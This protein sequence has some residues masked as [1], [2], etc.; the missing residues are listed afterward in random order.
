MDVR[1]D[2]SQAA[3]CDRAREVATAVIAPRVAEIDQSEEYPWDKVGALV[4][5]GFV[6]LTIL[7]AYGGAGRSYFD[8]AFVIEKM[9][10]V[11][12]VTG[13]IAVEIN[14]GAIGAIIAHGSEEQKKLAADMVL[15]GDKPAICITEPGVGSAATE[16]TTR[17]EKRGNTYVLNSAKHWISGGG[18]SRLHLVLARVFGQDGAEEGIDTFIAL[19]GKIEGLVIGRREPTMG[20]H[21][22]PETKVLFEDMALPP[23]MMVVPSR[24]LGKGFADLMAGCNAQRLVAGTVALDLTQGAYELALDHARERERF[25]RPIYEFQVLQWMLADMSIQLAVAR[26]LIHGAAVSARG[27][28]AFPDPLQ[29][30]Q[31]EIFASEMAIPVTNDALQSSAPPAILATG[32][33]SSWCAMPACLPS[34]A[35]RPR[36]CAPSSPPA[37]S[38]GVCPRRVTGS[39]SWRL[40]SRRGPTGPWRGIRGWASYRRPGPCGWCS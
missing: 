20:L 36:S 15:G 7:P 3:L 29:A 22:I 25:G 6:G 12:G 31:A 35:A 40:G 28:S 17:A 13:R 32:P 2:E 10:K 30:A 19:R 23:A 38:S 21:G 14:M 39:Q 9:A 37:P 27:A 4:D 5:A 24:G 18:V 33:W 8:A 34:V 1:L 26:A 11:C 16:M